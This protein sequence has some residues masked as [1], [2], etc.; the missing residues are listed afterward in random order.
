MAVD[1]GVAV[2]GEMFE[3]RQHACFLQAA[4]PSRDHRPGAH[5]ILAERSDVDDR[6]ARVVVDVRDGTEIDVHAEGA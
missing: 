4:H 3:R 6:I 1:I 2:A 5:R